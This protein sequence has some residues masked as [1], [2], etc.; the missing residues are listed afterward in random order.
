VLYIGSL[1]I[2]QEHQGLETS[3]FNKT[4]GKERY[5]DTS[6]HKDPH[7]VHLACEDFVTCITRNQLSLTDTWSR[8]SWK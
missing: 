4:T 8:A 5:F 3:D 6:V 7:F 2:E 1:K